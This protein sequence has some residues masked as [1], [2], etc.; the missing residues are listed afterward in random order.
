MKDK[1]PLVDLK[2]PNPYWFNL[3]LHQKL[4]MDTDLIVD[5]A[6]RRIDEKHYRKS[7]KCKKR[8]RAR[9]TGGYNREEIFPS[10]N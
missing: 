4:E 1:K 10:V 7:D 8:A 6:K 3:T 5:N 9:K 2:D